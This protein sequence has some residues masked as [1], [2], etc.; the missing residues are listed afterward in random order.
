MI[1]WESNNELNAFRLLDCKF[2]IR[3][4][5]EQ[6][7]KIVYVM[8]GVQRVHYPDI[9]V[10]TKEGKE[11]WEV[12][13]DPQSSSSEIRLRT[14]FMCQALPGWGYTYRLVYGNDLAQQ[15]RLSNADRLLR[16][17]R[18]SVTEYERE[19][20]R[21]T[22]KQ[23]GALQ[24]SEA[25]AGAYG[26]RGREVLCRLVLDGTLFMDMNAAWTPQ[27]RFIVRKARV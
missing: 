19:F 3:S 24:W 11:L 5:N 14:E 18:R 27:T 2:D 22:L 1:H 7:C 8:D 26:E 9:L 13:H 6:P 23:H 17:G 15:P 20:I 21:L 10:V 25:C 16:L 12:K 4:F